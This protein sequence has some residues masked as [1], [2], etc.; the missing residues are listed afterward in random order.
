MSIYDSLAEQMHSDYKTI[1]L[2]FTNVEQRL[3]NTEHEMREMRT[4]VAQA[5]DS[6]H[7]LHGSVME[8]LGQGEATSERFNELE[9]RVDALEK[10]SPA[11]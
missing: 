11:A 6:M 5:R 10:R 1:M 3:S 7:G 8:I 4:S 2:A 9:R